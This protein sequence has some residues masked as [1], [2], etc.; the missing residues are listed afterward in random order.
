MLQEALGLRSTGVYGEGTATAIAEW[1][2]RYGLPT[3]GYFGPMSRETFARFAA[4]KPRTVTV[5]ARRT[6]ANFGGGGGSGI[7]AV[8]PA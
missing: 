7:I 3:T 2:A 6:G 5:A 1:Q 8:W 4:V